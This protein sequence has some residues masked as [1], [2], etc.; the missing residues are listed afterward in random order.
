LRQYDGANDVEEPERREFENAEAID[1][2]D[3]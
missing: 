1:T 3:T 2:S